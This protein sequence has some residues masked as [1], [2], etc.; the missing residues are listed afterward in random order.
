MSNNGVPRILK[1]LR[2]LNDG[3]TQEQLAQQLSVSTSLIAKFE[4]ARQIPLPDTAEQIDGIFGSGSLVQETADDARKAVPPDWFQPWPEYEAEA[5]M[6]RWYEPNYVP[7]L[8]QTEAYARAV[9][10]VGMLPPDVAEQRLAHRLARQATVF[11][12]KT[13]PITSFIVDEAALRRGDRVMMKEQLLH[14]V[15]MSQRDRVLLHVVPLDAGLY[16]GQP[17]NFILATLPTGATV[18]Y[19]EGQLDG[20]TYQEPTKIAALV[21]AWEAIRS[22]AL[23]QDQSRDLIARMAEEL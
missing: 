10:A 14:L 13:P 4:T 12:R 9:L 16:A 18:A 6:L 1:F 2:T 19:T 23:P 22:V 3:M 20:R 11:D 7:G 8:L 15:E 5:D 21:N 17:G